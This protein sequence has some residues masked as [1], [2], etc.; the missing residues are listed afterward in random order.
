MINLHDHG[1]GPTGGTQGFVC[2]LC[3]RLRRTL[4]Y[5]RGLYGDDPKQTQLV[6]R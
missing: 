5:G 4:G 2:L 3:S 6:W 1:R